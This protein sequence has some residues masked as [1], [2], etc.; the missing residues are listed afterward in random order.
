[1][2]TK[3]YTHGLH[4]TSGTPGEQALACPKSMFQYIEDGY[5]DQ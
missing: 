1:M 4:R 3:I 5:S 2:A